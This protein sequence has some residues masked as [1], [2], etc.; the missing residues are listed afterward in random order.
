MYYKQ[1]RA[2]DIKR[3]LDC[4]IEEDDPKKIACYIAGATSLFNEFMDDIIESHGKTQTRQPT[5][6]QSDTQG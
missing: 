4:A 3:L 6:L 2:E 5:Q 1:N